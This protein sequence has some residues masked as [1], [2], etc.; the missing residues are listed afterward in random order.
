MWQHG[1]VTALAA[2]PPAITEDDLV[3]SQPRVRA[4]LVHRYE[5]L[6]ERVQV[7]IDLDKEGVQPIDPRMLEIGRGI[8]KDEAG[9]YR[10]GSK[11]VVAVDEPDEL[12]QGIDRVAIIEAQMAVIEEK[13]RAP[14]ARTSH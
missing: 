2:G 10:M 12:T 7:R 11:P 4:L 6:W 14:A 5:Q 3:D 13:L 8:L 9:I 1:S